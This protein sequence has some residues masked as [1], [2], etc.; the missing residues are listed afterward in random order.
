LPV[1]NL[2]RGENPSTSLPETS[3]G[4]ALGNIRVTIDEAGTVVTADDYYPFG[5]QMPGRSYNIAFSGN[6]YKFGSKEL[7]DENN[8]N[9]YHFEA[10]MYDPQIGRFTTIDPHSYNYPGW[11][12]YNYAANNPILITDPTGMDWY[13]QADSN[14]AVT[15]HWNEDLTSDNASDI[16]GEGQEY[17]GQAVVVISGSLNEKL[18]SDG[19]LF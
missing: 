2:F 1:Q 14:G 7:D 16:L 5:L 12:P 18:G 8:L 10:R 3:S 4:Q 13:G 6:Q 17:L 15:Y 9:L 19:T 11:T